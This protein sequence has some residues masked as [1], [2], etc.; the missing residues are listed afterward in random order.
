AYKKG[1]QRLGYSTKTMHPVV[2]ALFASLH[3]NDLLDLKA[4]QEDIQ[5]N[6][7]QEAETKIPDYVAVMLRSLTVFLGM[8]QDMVSE[9]RP[10]FVPIMVTEFLFDTSPDE[11]FT[12]WHIFAERFLRSAK[13]Q[14]CT[15]EDID[16][17]VDEVLSEVNF[18]EDE[19]DV[20]HW[21]W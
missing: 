20:N 11:M 4:R 9:N 16:A 7:P 6:D 17:T 2:L 21:I 14:T 5:L 13:G 8:I 19:D 1:A 3:T 15:D 12:F 10:P 18:D